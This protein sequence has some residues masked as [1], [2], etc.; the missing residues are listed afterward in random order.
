MS[1]EIL[2]ID[3]SDP[4]RVAILMAATEVFARYGFKR[5]S[6]EDIAKAAGLSRTAL[7]QSYRNKQ[8]IFR[9]LVAWYF[10][11]AADRVA[12][13]LQPG[14]PPEQAL[15]AAFVAKLGPE[16]KLM[17]DSPHGEELMDGGLDAA[18]DLVAEGERQVA[19][20]LEQWLLD[21]AAAGRIVLPDSDAAALAGT[22]VSALH[23]LKTT[24]G[25]GY[26]PLCASMGRLAALFGRGLRP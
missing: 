24:P 21:E 16:M 23:G 10:G 25:I 3:E 1:T 6:M 17:L 14:L 2:A 8:D 22:M 12:K 18:A 9:S 7:Y 13:A 26:D 5:T 19:G 4:R 15:G 11:Q 20:L